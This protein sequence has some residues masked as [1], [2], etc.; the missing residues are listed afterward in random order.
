M[1]CAFD[2]A[3]T[4]NVYRISDLLWVREMP[5]MRMS[6]RNVAN[7]KFGKKPQC[8]GKMQPLL[9]RL[10]ESIVCDIK[11][12]C[13]NLRLLSHRNLQLKQFRFVKWQ[14]KQKL[15]GT[16]TLAF[17]YICPRNGFDGTFRIG[18]KRSGKN[19][20]VY[21]LSYKT[22]V[23]DS[24]SIC[25]RQ[26]KNRLLTAENLALR[27]ENENFVQVHSSRIW[28]QKSASQREIYNTR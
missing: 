23:W 15:M 20:F 10:F 7:A 4:I 24:F 1:R 8:S 25:R 21:R 9:T 22:N 11:T 19:L 13:F 3:N 2:H 17:V 27:N 16:L 6:H 18:Q 14:V 5:L 28:T 12:S 26:M